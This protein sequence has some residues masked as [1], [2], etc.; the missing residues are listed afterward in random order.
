MRKLWV[1]CGMLLLGLSELYP[2]TVDNNN[3]YTINAFDVNGKAFSSKSWDIAGRPMLN[4]DWGKG[5]VKFRNGYSLN[6]VELQFNLVENELYFRKN[7][8]TYAFVEPIQEFDITYTEDNAS[9][10]SLL[11]CGYPF[12]GENTNLTFYEAVKDVR[13]VQLLKKTIKLVQTTNNYGQGTQKE[14]RQIVQWYVYDVK[15]ARV[16]PIKRDKSSLKQAFPSFAVQIDQIARKKKYK[17][18]NE[19]EIIELISLLNSQ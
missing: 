2:Q 7:N 18:C 1:I 3:S 9:H 6:A 17:F 15:K 4:P 12:S 13:L 8:L 5:I 10:N 11:R 14:Y 19:E 16:E